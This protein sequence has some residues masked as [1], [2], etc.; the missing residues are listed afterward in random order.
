MPPDTALGQAASAGRDLRLGLGGSSWLGTVLCAVGCWRHPGLHPRDASGVTGRCQLSPG[1][2][3]TP[4]GKSLPQNVHKHLGALTC[5]AEVRGDAA[6]STAHRPVAAPGLRT[7]AGTR[8]SRSRRCCHG[9]VLATAAA[10]K[11]LMSLCCRRG[12]CP[13]VATRGRL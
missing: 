12:C 13:R 9:L 8:G 4:I 2:H 5:S 10:L 6:A 7:G 3:S 11:G 1:G